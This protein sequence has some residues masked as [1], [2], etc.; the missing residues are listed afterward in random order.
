MHLL[1]GQEDKILNIYYG[2]E[3]IDKENFI[4]DEIKKLGYD[5]ENPVRI[6]VPDQ[7]TLEAE[8]R[9]F[10]FLN[11]KS[12]IGLDVCSFSR[13]AHNIVS[14]VFGRNQTFIDK[15]G[16]HMLLRKIA[17]EQEENLKVY[18]SNLQKSAFTKMTNDFISELK[19]YN[20]VPEDFSKIYQDIKGN[21]LLND[22]LEDLALIYQEYEKALEGKYLDSE[23]FLDLFRTGIGAS[24]KIP[25]EKVWIYGFDSFSP[26]NMQVIE[27]LAK[28]SGELNLVLT[29]DKNCRDEDLF[30]LPE[31]IIKQFL[32]AFG[33]ENVK[34]RK[35]SDAYGYKA[36]FARKVK[37]GMSGSEE[38]EGMQTLKNPALLHLE[39]ELYASAPIRV[40]SKEDKKDAIADGIT[41]CE[42]ANLYHEAESAAAYILWLLREKNYRYRDVVLICNDLKTRGNILS[43]VFEEYGLPLFHD[44][45]RK[46]INAN[47]AIYLI[48]MLEAVTNKFRTSDIFR[49]LKS[50]LT[51]FAID[52][53]EELENYALKYRIKGNMWKK[54]FKYGDFEYSQEELDR[55]NEYRERISALLTELQN[56]GRESHTI[57]DFVERYYI[58]LKEKANIEENIKTF[59]EFQL[60]HSGE[61]YVDET[62]QIFSMVVDILN[63]IVEIIG[64]EEFVFEEFLDLFKVGLLEVEVGRLPSSIDDLMLGTMQRTRTGSARA[65]VIV[66]ANEGVLPAGN[67]SEELFAAE[68]LELLAAKGYVL[69]KLDKIRLQEERLAIY[70][71]LAKPSRHL[72][73]GYSIG[74]EEGKEIRRSDIVD[75]ILNIFP[76]LEIR[77]DILNEDDDLK[78][79]GGKFSTLR[80]L[81]DAMRRVRKGEYSSLSPIWKK[82]EIWY[83]ENEKSRLQSI[84]KGLDFDNRAKPLDKEFTDLFFKNDY[85]GDKTLSP[86][87]LEKY[88]HCPFSYFIS[89]ALKPDELRKFEVA[90]REIGD[91]YHAC[92]MQVTRK[93]TEDNLWHTVSDEECRELLRKA[94]E[95]ETRGYRGGLFEFG[96]EEGYKKKRIE[97]TCMKSLRVLIYHIREG[98][99]KDSKFEVKFGK[100]RSIEPITVIMPSGEKVYIEGAID[101]L[102]Y[103]ENDRVKIIDYKSGNL[104]LNIDEIEAGYRLQL[105]LYVTAAQEGVRKPAGMFYFHIHSPRLKDLYG[106]GSEEF[107]ASVKN[108]IIRS[109][110]LDGIMINDEDT[111]GAIVGD[112]DKKSKIADVN[113]NRNGELKGKA[114]ISEEAF[115]MLQDT[116]VSKV[117]ELIE[118][119][120]K[121][122]IDIF[123]MRVK[124]N[125]TCDYCEFK[126]ICRFDL[127]FKGCEYNDVK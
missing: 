55:I 64:E 1:E 50:G 77:K 44:E 124:D 24:E 109:F 17:K 34:I 125:T 59:M 58:F 33:N 84:K 87:R 91:I 10:R 119:M 96:K 49:V 4:F 9:A 27:E 25:Q 122:N 60:Q 67:S 38:H 65:L 12:L 88:S 52:E 18:K 11:V 47:P 85:M 81:S 100:G 111:V 56:I 83:E 110:K 46:I 70:R 7:Y 14:E 112:F 8:R 2:R 115:Q 43:R 30:V 31:G 72:W 95:L 104:N 82:A 45:K 21:K 57:K 80:H 28:K 22:K 73:I 29:Y 15:Y 101:R 36:G 53:I 51:N 78:L 68:E 69:G 121:G 93:L 39:R 102:D 75:T 71:N 61:D 16:R 120:E 26:K 23:D 98:K 117:T 37:R 62:R 123:P 114:L 79:I 86:S 90:G 41:I 48:S 97:E 3:S 19:Q 107:E 92:I 126:G 40:R 94:V 32:N 5:A 63:Q 116:V 6:I 89:Y 103:L 118:D 76:D 35:I 13:L 105:M 99:V 20:I 106:E 66:G 74:D 127:G 108:E 113:M 42:A 54:P